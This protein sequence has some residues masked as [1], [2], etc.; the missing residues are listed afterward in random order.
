MIF[1]PRWL[2]QTFC[3]SQDTCNDKQS[4]H[5]GFHPIAPLFRDGD[6]KK[7]KNIE[8]FCQKKQKNNLLRK[9]CY[10]VKAATE[11]VSY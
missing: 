7:N 2:E 10:D 11:L 6:H 5:Q 4:S 9:T 3:Q 8:I 1:S